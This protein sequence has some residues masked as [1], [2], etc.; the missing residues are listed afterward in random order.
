M[1]LDTVED[2]A[3]RIG[4]CLD[5]L[6]RLR[7]RHV[8]ACF[9]GRLSGKEKLETKSRLARSGRALDHVDVVARES[10]AEDVIEAKHP[11]LR[12]GRAFA[13]H[14]FPSRFPRGA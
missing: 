10:S 11:R 1:D 6:P 14:R 4:D 12:G 7:Q 8:E 13:A 9:S 2:P 5:L 3:V